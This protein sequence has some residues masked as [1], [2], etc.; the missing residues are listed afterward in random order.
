MH[1]DIRGSRDAL[2]RTRILLLTEYVSRLQD[3]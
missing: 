1:D 2:V 3:K